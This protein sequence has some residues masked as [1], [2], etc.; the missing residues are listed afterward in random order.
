MNW[1]LIVVAAI[2]LGYTV[3]GFSKGFL[4]IVYSLISWILI[5]IFIMV[6]APYIQNYLMTNTGI[7]GNVVLYCE[8][9]LRTRVEKEMGMGSQEAVA[10]LSENEVFA[11]LTEK[12]PETLIEEIKMHLDE[13]TGEFIENNGI[14]AK[15]AVA[16]ADLFL[17]GISTLAAII[18]G[19]IASAIISM[20]LGLISKLPII[21][22]MD[23]LLGLAAGAANGL[24][25][26]WI[27]FYLVAIL[28]ATEFGTNIITQ[29]NAN[30]YLTLLYE[31]NPILNLLI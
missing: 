27:G 15:T 4:K 26:V 2:L 14:Y 28:G 19:L 25:V 9:M 11:M 8:D 16:V 12:L 29:I 18:L 20:V 31:N 13:V 10:A 5:L 1:V 22:A 21:G 3:A 30:E 6:A 23:R 24:L 7:Y 17:K